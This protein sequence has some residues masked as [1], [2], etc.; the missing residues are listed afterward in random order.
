MLFLGFQ[1]LNVE[2]GD[3]VL[4]NFTAMELKF[5]KYQGTGNDFIIL[6]GWEGLPEISAEQIK[7]L[8]DRRFGIGADG[9][10][11]I[12]KSED[13]DFKMR[14]FN[15]DGNPG[16]MCGNGGRCL[17]QFA[18]SQSYIGKSTSFVA[19]DGSHKAVIQNEKDWVSLQMGNVSEVEVLENGD[20][21]LNTGSP[22]YIKWVD[23]PSTVD[24]FSEG[25][26]IRNSSRYFQEGVNVNFV[27]VQQGR[28]EVRTFE[29]GVEDETLSC[30]T[31]VTAS[32]LASVFMKKISS[33]ADGAEVITPGGELY[34]KFHQLNNGFDNV[35]LE[36]PAEL[37]FEGTVELI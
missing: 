17:T 5:Y 15:S 28:V 37:V 27:S 35:W 22:H 30:G 26:K 18:Y 19:S 12:S 20:C 1:G 25:K 6:D 3:F 34:V 13:A 14:Y 7:R 2:A 33:S 9:L 16:S 32:V 10:M 29:R 31:G 21:F 23:D 8:C 11:I 4:F 36:G 24:V